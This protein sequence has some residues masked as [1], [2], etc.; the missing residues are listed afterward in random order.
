[1]AGQMITL[2][3]GTYRATVYDIHTDRMGFARRCKPVV[4]DLV[5]T[6]RD[7]HGADIRIE[8]RVTTFTAGRAV[9]LEGYRLLVV[10]DE[11]AAILWKMHEGP[12]P[13]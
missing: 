6:I 11:A 9:H 8:T 5:E 4:A 13:K 10:M 7:E 12:W 3:F 1:M 2:D